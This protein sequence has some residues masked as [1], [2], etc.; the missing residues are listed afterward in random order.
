MWT[1]TS[2]GGL[3]ELSVVQEDTGKLFYT[4]K[5]KEKSIVEKSPLG[6][7]GIGEDALRFVGEARREI[8]EA[9]SIP[10]GKKAVYTDEGNEFVLTFACEIGSLGLHLRAYDDGAAFRYE[11]SGEASESVRIAGEE[12]GFCLAEA[13]GD[14]WLQTWINS[15]EGRYERSGWED[16]AGRRFGMPGLVHDAVDGL[17]ALVTEAGVYNNHGNYCASHLLGMGPRHLQIGFAPEEMGQPLTCCLPLSTPWRVVVVTDHLDTLVNTTLTYNLNP[18]SDLADV[19]WVRPTRNV[20]H[21]WSFENGAQL[22]TEMKRYADYAAAIGFEGITVDGVIM[23]ND[24]GLSYLRDLCEYAHEKN[25]T[26][27]LWCMLKTIDTPQKARKWV[28][29]WTECGIDGLKVDFFESD[30]Q[31]TMGQYEMV[32]EILT[33]H[34]LMINFHGATKCSGEGRSWPNLMAAEG[35]GGMEQYKWCDMVDSVHNCTVPFT[36]NVIG[37]MDY[38]PTAFS[39]KNR[40]TTHGHQLALPVV[41]ECGATHIAAGIYHLEAW[42]GTDFL[43]RT[44]AAYDEVRVLSGFPGHHAAVMRRK[45]EEWLLGCITHKALPLHLSLD[46]LPDGDFEAEIYEDDYSGE[47]LRVRHQ[48]VSA[49][50]MLDLSLLDH[51]GAGVYIARRV[52]PLETAYSD[53]YMTANRQ[54]IPVASMVTGGGS[55]LLWFSPEKWTV[56]LNGRVHLPVDSPLND[57]YMIRFFYAAEEATRIRLTTSLGSRE[58]DLPATGSP[59]VMMTHNIVAALPAGC[60]TVEVQRISGGH[61]ALDCVH[62]L[63]NHPPCEWDCEMDRAQLIGS[64]ERV[65]DDRGRTKVVGLGLGG[66]W[67]YEEMDLPQDGKY[68]LHLEYSAGHSRDLCIE[69]NDQPIKK[70]NLYCSSGWGA[71]TTW[72]NC[73]AAEI[74][75]DFRKGKNRIRLFLDDAAAPHIYKVK[76]LKVGKDWFRG[77]HFA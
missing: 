29:L 8:R 74:L 25:L 34:R 44:K 35:I 32:A 59:R 58:W 6:I 1:V 67:I 31:Y 61:P 57:R 65:T 37:P 7:C 70:I 24:L 13:F 33:E 73:D 43:R 4:I 66:E 51:G 19:S 49:K 27:W 22:Y 20:W 16:V 17:W 41:Y 11:V 40:N 55:E 18:P 36:R 56:Q 64:A 2:P 26:V 3:V 38:T 60:D 50:T 48:S 28:P 52:T 71:F 62:I 72:E 75:M 39:H 30:S 23:N 45:G 47:I 14:V 10:A 53:G 42:R 46:F 63:D 9:Y 68:L 21:W 15:Y 77:K 12:T 69:V 54:I 5:R 76:V